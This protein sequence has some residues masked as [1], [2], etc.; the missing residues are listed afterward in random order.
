MEYRDRTR[1]LHEK[2]R[3][4]EREA[5]AVALDIDGLEPPEIATE[6]NITRQAV[7]THLDRAR[8]KA[9]TAR[10]TV[11]LLDEMGFVD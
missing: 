5:E 1:E 7:H 10:K 6:M 2:T 4:S 3:L 9:E 11:S 8:E